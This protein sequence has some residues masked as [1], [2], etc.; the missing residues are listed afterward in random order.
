MINLDL[1]DTM[2]MFY[3]QQTGTYPANPDGLISGANLLANARRHEGENENSHYSHYVAAVADPD[4][5]FGL[6][7]ESVFVGP[8]G[9][10]SDLSIRA[11]NVL[12][13]RRAAL[14]AATDVEPLGP[15]YGPDGSW[16]GFISYSYAAY[17]GCHP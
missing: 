8:P 13:A 3:Q 16:Q 6:G 11:N 5:N 17:T 1:M 7:L 2:C 12:N 10:P 14:N 9:N 15:N 4:V